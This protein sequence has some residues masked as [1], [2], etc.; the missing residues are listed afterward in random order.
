MPA[1]RVRMPPPLWGGVALVPL[2]FSRSAQWGPVHK[3]QPQ[4]NK[5]DSGMWRCP[6]LSR[7]R[8]PPPPLNAGQKPCGPLGHENPPIFS[9]SADL[10]RVR[11][12]GGPPGRKVVNRDAFRDLG[13]RETL[14]FHKPP[15]GFRNASIL[16]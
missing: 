13:F 16:R 7:N 4:Q 2:F 9:L 10:I 5:A 1:I 15:P 14:E 6:T 8:A 3:G 11:K 12:A